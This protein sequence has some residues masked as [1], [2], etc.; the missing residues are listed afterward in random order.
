M[1]DVVDRAFESIQNVRWEEF[2]RRELPTDAVESIECLIDAFASSGPKER[3]KMTQRVD[4]SFACVFPAFAKRAA[5]ESVRR[6]DPA[7]L[8]RGLIALAIENAKVDL[9]DTLPYLAFVYHSACKLNVSALEL[10]RDT[11]K[12]ACPQFRRL[13]ESFLNRDEAART[14]ESFHYK[15]SGEGTSFTYVYFEPPSRLPS[16]IEWRIRGFFRRL[17]RHLK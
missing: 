15:E 12:I 7:L 17:R 5:V 3:E 6:N 2:F 13:L 16:K 4:R 10:F 1:A 11:A 8:K 14:L 9:R